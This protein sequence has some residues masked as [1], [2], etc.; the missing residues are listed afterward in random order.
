MT[1]DNILEK[2]IKMI[3]NCQAVENVKKYCILAMKEYAHIKCM[4]QKQICA[5][6]AEADY[7]VISL[8]EN[9]PNIVDSIEVYVLKESIL[10]AP[11]AI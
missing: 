1:A 4:E 8:D 7:T 2:H 10:Q 6:H 5:D 11:N 9:E 3:L